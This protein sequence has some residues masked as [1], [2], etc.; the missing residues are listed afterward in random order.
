MQALKAAE[1]T[2][3]PEVIEGTRKRYLQALEL[4]TGVK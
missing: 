1:V 4:L 2:L 3:P